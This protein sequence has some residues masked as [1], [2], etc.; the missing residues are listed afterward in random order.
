MT[1]DIRH[2]DNYYKYFTVFIPTKQITVPVTKNI[3]FIQIPT[4]AFLINPTA[5]DILRYPS[6]RREI[7]AKL[8]CNGQGKA[9]F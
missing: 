4:R 7:D 8:M 3:V 9:R 6:K 5:V 2:G 1:Y